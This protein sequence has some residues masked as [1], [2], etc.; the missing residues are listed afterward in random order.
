MSIMNE[1]IKLYKVR[2]GAYNYYI[3]NT[4]GNEDANMDLVQRKLTR[5]ILCGVDRGE[6]QGRRLFYYGNLA[7]IT[8]DDEVVWIESYKGRYNQFADNINLELRDEL[9]RK[10]GLVETTKTI[11][12]KD[13]VKEDI[14][15]DFQGVSFLHKIMK[16]VGLHN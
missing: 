10:L 12:N 8:V 9:N 1:E 6:I 7:I 15:I 13:L 2:D 3:K 4:R 5:N 16:M 11:D 14:K